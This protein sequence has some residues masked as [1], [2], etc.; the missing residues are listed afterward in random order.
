MA[1]DQTLRSCALPG[2]SGLDGIGLIGG[3]V[4]GLQH[5]ARHAA[6]NC[7][8]DHLDQHEGM[9]AGRRDP[10]VTAGLACGNWVQ[11]RAWGGQFETWTGSP[12]LGRSGDAAAEDSPERSPRA[13]A[14]HHLNAVTHARPG[15]CAPGVGKPLQYAPRLAT[16]NDTAEDLDLVP[17]CARP[18]PVVA[19]GVGA[20]RY[21]DPAG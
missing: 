21:N 8:R 3:V 13:C 12:D 17:D 16:A 10:E 7:A 18:L 4:L 19:A 15:R 20:A 9:G 11:L 1:H 14:L 5:A 2:S 6:R